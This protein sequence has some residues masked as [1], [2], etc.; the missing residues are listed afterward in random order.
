MVGD[1]V[2]VVVRRVACEKQTVCAMWD[3]KGGNALTL[4]MTAP[5]IPAAPW[6]CCLKTPEIGLHTDP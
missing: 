1:L 4:R 6:P 5:F 3:E 2:L